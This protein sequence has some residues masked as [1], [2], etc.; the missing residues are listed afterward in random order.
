MV[1]DL[2]KLATVGRLHI[3]KMYKIFTNII[4]NQDYDWQVG[5]RC[6]PQ[7]NFPE[8]LGPLL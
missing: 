1:R 2:K 5:V 4:F 3:H 7:K 8:S 6:P